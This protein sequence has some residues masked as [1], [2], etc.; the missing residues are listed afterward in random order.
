MAAA[1][2]VHGDDG[3]RAEGGAGGHH[4]VGPLPV[5]GTFAQGVRALRVSV[6][7]VELKRLP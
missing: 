4:V 7:V 2:G 6:Q 1:L 5:D 3:R